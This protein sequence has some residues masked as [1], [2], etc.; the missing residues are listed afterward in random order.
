[1]SG[2]NVANRRGLLRRKELNLYNEISE[3]RSYEN[4]YV[5]KNDRQF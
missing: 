2:S 1:M 3:W 5:R 4:K